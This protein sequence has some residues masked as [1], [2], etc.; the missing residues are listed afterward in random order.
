MRVSVLHD[1]A[2]LASAVDERYSVKRVFLDD[3]VF[4]EAFNEEVGEVR[5]CRV[6]HLA[7]DEARCRPVQFEIHEG[8]GI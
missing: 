5:L 2:V 6:A 3:R 1:V 8:D 4:L 7:K